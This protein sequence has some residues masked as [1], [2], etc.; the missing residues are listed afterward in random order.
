MSVTRRDLIA[1]TAGLA[2]AS[3]VGSAPSL[4]QQGTALN[5]KPEPDTV[6]GIENKIENGLKVEPGKSTQQDG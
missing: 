4:A 3:L 2:G 6:S 5:F 1:G